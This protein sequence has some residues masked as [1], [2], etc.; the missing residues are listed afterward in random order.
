MGKI[1]IVAEVGCNHMGDLELAKKLIKTIALYCNADIVKFQKRTP[2]EL[3]SEEEYNSVHPVIE[4][5]FGVTYGEHREFLEFDLEEHK[6]LKKIC[7]D[8]NVIYSSSVWD[9]QAAKEICSLKPKYIKIPSASNLDFDMISWI[10]SNYAGEIHISLGMT[11]HEEEDK[12]FNIV[13]SKNRN[14]DLILYSCTSAYPVN[15][16][17]ICLLE[18]KRLRNKFGKSIKD[19]GFSGHH[20]GIF[21]DMAALSLGAKIFERHVTLD[22]KFKGT[23]HVASLEP[24]DLKTLVKELKNLESALTYKSKEILEVETFQRN[25]LKRKIKK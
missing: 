9:L 25:K 11:S 20:L 6:Y 23:D 1:S 17:D 21:V 13:K 15:Y 24:E 5:S 18:I 2:R 14:K 7:E 10:C 19:V 16:S 22:K 8:E 4:N 12:I 3:L